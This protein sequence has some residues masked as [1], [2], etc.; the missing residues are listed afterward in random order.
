MWNNK[1]NT[2]HRAIFDLLCLILSDLLSS[3][4]FLIALE[5]PTGEKS[6]QKL[7]NVENDKD[8]KEDHFNEHDVVLNEHE[9]N[10]EE[11]ADQRHEDEAYHF[12]RILCLT[13]T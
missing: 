7:K 1:E 6:K 4:L 12:E 11:N 5:L 3:L 13:L 2:N 10:A 9:I 8:N